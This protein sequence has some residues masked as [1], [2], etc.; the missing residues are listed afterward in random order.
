MASIAASPSDIRERGQGRNWAALVHSPSVAAALLSGVIAVM[1]AVIGPMVA[2]NS[3][4]HEKALEVR[5]ALATD[6]SKSFTMAV[7]SSQRVA[8][9]LIYGPTGDRE[10]NAAVVQ[11]AYN[12]GLGR[13]QIDGGR[14]SAELS[15]R[16]T[17]NAVVQD[18]KRYRYA[19]TRFYRLSAVL[20]GHDR[21]YLITAL[22]QYFDETRRESW[23]AGALS[24][25]VNWH[26]LTKNRRLSS[27]LKYRRN[28][29]KLSDTFLSLGDAFVGRVL[30][31][32][33]EI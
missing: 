3:Q 16:Y 2:R 31:L 32:Q 17:G 11:A 26:A 12:T 8:S 25:T 27:S 1:V 6:M 28:Y 18:W 10:Q 4:N 19:V 20:P 7:G 21:P 22:R 5:T 15:A 9:G 13:W 30:A 29:N 23:A 24:A 33:P 14:I